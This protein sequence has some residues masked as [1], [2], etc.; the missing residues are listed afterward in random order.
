MCSPS[1][2]GN[3]KNPVQAADSGFPSLEA[4]EQKTRHQHC[5]SQ[6]NGSQSACAQECGKS[7]CLWSWQFYQGTGPGVSCLQ[8]QLSQTFQGCSWELVSAHLRLL[9]GRSTNGW[10]IFPFFPS[11]FR[12]FVYLKDL[13]ATSEMSLL[14]PDIKKIKRKKMVSVIISRISF[15]WGLFLGLSLPGNLLLLSVQRHTNEGAQK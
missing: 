10:L 13:K 12:C 15:V 6:L 5:I 1:S 9:E 2:H 4:P 7:L 3:F 11:I 14:S 8:H